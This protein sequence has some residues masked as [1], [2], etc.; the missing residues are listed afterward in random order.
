[1]AGFGTA[2]LACGGEEKYELSLK[3]QEGSDEQCV[4][5]LLEYPSIV[6]GFRQVDVRLKYDAGKGRFLTVDIEPNSIEKKDGVLS[7]YLCLAEEMLKHTSIEIEW[8]HH[9]QRDDGMYELIMCHVD[10]DTGDLHTLLQS[11]GKKPIDPNHYTP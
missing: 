10:V 4:P 8:Y 3:R 7:S 6:S 11:G 1:M 2:A 9:V 5:L